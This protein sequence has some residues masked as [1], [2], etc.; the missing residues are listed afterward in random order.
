MS[1]LKK[2]L[3]TTTAVLLFVGVSGAPG[4]LANPPDSLTCPGNQSLV[5]IETRVCPARPNRPADVV[6]R[7][8]CVNP[9]GKVHCG[10]F[11]NCPATSP[12]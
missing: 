4:A 9:A 3:F 11:P 7:A 12:S 8:C 6:Q 10:N 1:M 2:R 5:R